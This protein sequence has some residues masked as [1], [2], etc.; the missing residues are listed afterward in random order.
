MPLPLPLDFTQAW[1]HTEAALPRFASEFVEAYPNPVKEGEILHIRV[2]QPNL[3]GLFDLRV[4]DTLGRKIASSAQ[5]KGSA[6]M[7]TR[8]F[9]AGVYLFVLEYE[10]NLQYKT[11]VVSR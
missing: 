7:D 5:N 3:D 4:Y 6:T 2:D 1:P 11:V 8:G 9:A 10:R